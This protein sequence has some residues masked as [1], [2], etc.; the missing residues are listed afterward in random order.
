MTHGWVFDMRAEGGNPRRARA[1]LND[2]Q[3]SDAES[4]WTQYFPAMNEFYTAV[5]RPSAESS[6]AELSRD[7]DSDHHSI[8]VWDCMGGDDHEDW[9]S[10]GGG[11]H[12]SA[13]GGHHT[14][15]F[16]PTTPSASPSCGNLLENN[17]LYLDCLAG[18]GADGN[19]P[20]NVLYETHTTRPRCW[21]VRVEGTRGGRRR[22]P[23]HYPLWGSEAVG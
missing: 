20:C 8:G 11:D 17:Q 18:I 23:A 19:S 7:G 16:S 15:T 10:T 13:G 1:L 21:L 5:V 14:D 2:E 12:D 9:D 3:Q 22:S 6:T 4:W